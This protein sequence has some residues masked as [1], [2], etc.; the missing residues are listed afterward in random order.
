[1]NFHLRLMKKILLPAFMIL[2]IVFLSCQKEIGD[3]IKPLLQCKIVRGFYYD[4]NGRLNDSADF[5]YDDWGKIVKWKAGYGY[6]DY[7]Y[8]GNNIELRTLKKIGASELLF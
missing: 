4:N 8:N 7:L 6:Y 3:N 1:M 5:I 2:S